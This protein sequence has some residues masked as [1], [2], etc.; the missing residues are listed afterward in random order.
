MSNAARLFSRA[1]QL[2]A[3]TD[4]GDAG[5]LQLQYAL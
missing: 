4:A 5:V 2:H 3:G 1:R